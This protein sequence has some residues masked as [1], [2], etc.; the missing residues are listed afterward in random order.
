M[1]GPNKPGVALVINDSAGGVLSCNADFVPPAPGSVITF[2]LT[3]EGVL[4]PAMADGRLPTPP[5]YPAPAAPWSVNVG[6][7][8]APPCAA[9]FAGLVY[10]G[11][12]QVN[13]C[14]PDGVPRTANVPLTFRSDAATS[15]PAG[16]D[17][18]P[19][20]VTHDRH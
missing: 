7:I 9:T 14:I 19:P 2:F 6:G 15:A 17:L 3:G 8:D 4:T 20:P 5:P 18:Q 13:T 10:A 1:C 11:V 16:I 12:T